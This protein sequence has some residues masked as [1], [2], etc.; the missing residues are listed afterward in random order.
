MTNH[1]ATIL[2]VALSVG[3]VSCAAPVQE[4]VVTKSAQPPAKPPARL[5]GRGKVTSIPLT[6]FFALHQS[7]Q[8]LVFDARPAFFYGLG[9]IPGAINLPKTGSVEQITKREAEIKAALAAKKTI[10]VYCT[11]PTCPDARTVAIH[12]SSFGYPSSTL[13]GGWD[14]WK[15]AGLPTE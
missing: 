3:L 11:N 5:N 10:V 2:T 4:P 14:S 9:H 8:V 15:E 6:D 12:L 13:S 1:Q 7:D